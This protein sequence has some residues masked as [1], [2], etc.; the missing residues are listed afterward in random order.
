M[1]F[2]NGIIC[3]FGNDLYRYK[4]IV[5]IKGEPEKIVLQ[6]VHM[7][8]EMQ[9]SKPWQK[10]ELHKNAIIF[11]GKNLDRN[12]LTQGFISCLVRK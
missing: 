8:F 5:A 4:G 1:Y 7:L 3:T 11:I 12:I 6:G 9:P 10:D 2:I